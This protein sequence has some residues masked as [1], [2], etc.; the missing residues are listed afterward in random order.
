MIEPTQVTK[1]TE[2][3]RLA[4]SFKPD[5]TNRI[6]DRVKQIENRSKWLLFSTAFII[7][8]GALIFIFAGQIATTENSSYHKV[9]DSIAGGCSSNIIEL[10]QLKN[11]IS[12]ASTKPQAIDEKIASIQNRL[13][14]ISSM[15]KSLPGTIP[16]ST[17]AKEETNRRIYISAIITRVSISSLMAFIIA[18]FITLH[19]SSERLLAFYNSRLDALALGSDLTLPELERLSK[20]FLPEKHDSEKLPD[21]PVK[22]VIEL[23]KHLGTA[24]RATTEKV[25]KP[26]P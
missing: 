15:V 8:F 24:T 22:H 26:K 11:A 6:N 25:T 9:A 16:D 19:R 10:Q 20:L 12:N 5:Y 18:I 1:K 17:N 23:L 2:H 4:L 21:S 13:D 14:S 7:I 3:S